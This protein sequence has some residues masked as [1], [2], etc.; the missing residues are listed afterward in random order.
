MS[1]KA[2]LSLVVLVILIGS[3]EATPISDALR[4]V[5]DLFVKILGQTENVLSFARFTDKYGKNYE[6]KEE[7]K[8][9]FSVFQDNVDLIGSTNKKGLSFKLGVNSKFI[10]LIM[11]L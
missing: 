3:H 8:H 1:V 11:K 7:I 2:I 6:N 4:K 9:R 10:V 5:E